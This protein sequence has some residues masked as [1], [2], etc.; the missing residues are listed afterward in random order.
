MGDPRRI[1]CPIDFSEFSRR[2]LDHALAVARCYRSTVTALHVVAPTPV[3]APVPY[4][5]GADAPPPPMML[6][7]ADREAIAAQLRQLVDAE[8]VPGIR[9][10][11]LIAEAPV[12]Y[13]E[14]LVQAERLG[15]D[16]VVIGTHGRSGFER[17]FLGSTA[18]RVLRKATCPIMT[19]PPK[20]PEAMPRGPVPFT[21]ILCAVDFSDSSSLGL[22]Y[23]VSLARESKAALT[24]AHV[25]ETRP[26]YY[27]FSP[28]VAIDL[29]AWLEE[30]RTRLRDMVPDAARASCA[31]TEAV[32]EGSAHHEI[33]AL[34]GE[35]ESDLIVMGVRGRG[36]A[37]LWFFGST[38][39]HVIREARCG[40]LTVRG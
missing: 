37:D 8:Q 31:V 33:L 22:D 32:R 16:L 15:A 4:F 25:I 35:L 7:P 12:A 14:I 17:L 40:V 38:T 13:R 19:V 21:R 5:F 39:H 1:L 26:L 9:V 36:A 2:A 11:T 18:E 24:L 10:D 28:P 27:D 34:A 3:V 6:P 30:A 29:T 23:A 20:A